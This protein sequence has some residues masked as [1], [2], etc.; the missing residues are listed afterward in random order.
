MVTHSNRGKVLEQMCEMSNK[1]YFNNNVLMCNKVAVPVKILKIVKNR[2]TGFLESKSQLDYQGVYKGQSFSYD[3]KETKL[4]YLPLKNIKPHQIEYMRNA[5]KFGEITFLVVGDTMSHKN[6]ICSSEVV[7]NHYELWKENKSKRGFGNIQL[8][9][10]VEV[11]SLDVPV[12]YV[13]WL[14]KV[15]CCGT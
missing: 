15:I 8:D 14:E 1:I 5:S 11:G 13:V 6:Y 2:V 7:I 9:R 10:M 12:N 4:N 3:A